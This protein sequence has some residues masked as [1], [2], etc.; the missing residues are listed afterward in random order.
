MSFYKLPNTSNVRY[1][2]YL[3]QNNSSSLIEFIVRRWLQLAHNLHNPT[4]ESN[5]LVICAQHLSGNIRLNPRWI[6]QIREANIVHKI[7]IH[8]GTRVSRITHVVCNFKISFNFPATG[9]RS[10]KICAT[11]RI[12]YLTGGRYV[13]TAPWPK[14]RALNLINSSRR[15]L[16]FPI[17]V[18]IW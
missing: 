11:R 7:I 5:I 6:C 16:I 2:I 12:C 18:A 15:L 10:T 17:T 13:C 4:G 3:S 9:T 8:N 1:D 14:R